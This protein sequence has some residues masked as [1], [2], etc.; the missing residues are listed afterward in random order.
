MSAPKLSIVSWN[1]KSYTLYF[2]VKSRTTK[3]GNQLSIYRTHKCIWFVNFVLLLVFGGFGGRRN[4]NIS[5]GL[6][7]QMHFNELCF[8]GVSPSGLLSVNILANKRAGRKIRSHKK[9]SK[10]SK[11]L[12]VS[13]LQIL[14]LKG[15]CIRLETGNMKC[16]LYVLSKQHEY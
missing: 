4:T 9:L 12:Q 15:I 16:H 6:I 10:F 11:I 3:K 8:S 2:H 5:A 1:I 14:F 13:A 7:L